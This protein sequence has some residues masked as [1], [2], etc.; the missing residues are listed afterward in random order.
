VQN[1]DFARASEFKAKRETI[2]TGGGESWTSATSS[3]ASSM[4]LPAPPKC[5]IGLEL[6]ATVP[7]QIGMC[8]WMWLVC[9][10]VC[11]S[12]RGCVV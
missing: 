9:L 5:I 2:L 3:S 1:E 10:R 11:E 4:L 6:T 8:V 7:R 12:V